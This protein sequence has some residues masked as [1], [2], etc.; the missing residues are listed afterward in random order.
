MVVATG[1]HRR[2]LRF[3]PDRS[4]RRC[5]SYRCRAGFLVELRD[6][7]YAAD[8]V[9]IA[10]GPFQTP[11]VP[12]IAEQL[13]VSFVQMHSTT[14]A[15][16]ATCPTGPCWWWA[17]G[18]PATRSPKSSRRPTRSISPS[19]R[20]RPRCAA[21]ARPRLVPVSR[22]RPHKVRDD[23]VAPGPEAVAPRDAD[24]SARAA[25][26]RHGIEL[27]GRA[28]EASSTEIRFAD[29]SALSAKAVIWTTGFA[30]DHSFVQAPILDENRRIEHRRA[31]SLLPR[32]ALAAH[33]RL[34]VPGWVK[35]DAQYI[36][37][38]ATRDLRGA[39]RPHG[40]LAPEH[41]TEPRDGG[42]SFRRGC[43][44]WFRPRRRRRRGERGW[45]TRRSGAAWRRA[46]RAA[47]RRARGQ[48]APRSSGH[49]LPAA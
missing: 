15:G 19:A 30:L 11:R 28:G 44:R 38:A 42:G 4:A 35:D 37:R 10:T 22:S 20:G 26:R 21:A 24:R 18:I 34:H 41:A 7:A 8:Q 33:P 5:L 46:C 14:T 9:V 40:H 47:S 31:R 3:Q 39:G 17:A 32:P 16:R 49:R 13:D 23:P 29:G 43:E 12:P 6:R 45:R 2:P 27:R 36:A 25:R 1:L 48:T